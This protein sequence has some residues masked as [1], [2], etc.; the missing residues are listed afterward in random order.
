MIDERLKEWDSIYKWGLLAHD[1]TVKKGAALFPR[2]DIEKELASLEAALKAAQAESVANQSAKTDEPQ[3]S[4]IT[5]DDFAKVHLVT[6]EVIASEAVKGSKK[7]LKN[8]VKMGNETRTILSGIAKHYSPEEMV[9]KKVVVVANLAPRKMMGE[10][11]HGMILC[12]EDSEGKLSL[13]SND[14][15]FGGGLEVK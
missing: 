5:I 9:G 6:G 12:A 7:L 15:N 14:K 11:S 8:T 1:I 10:V 4:E 3:F 2:I 13:I